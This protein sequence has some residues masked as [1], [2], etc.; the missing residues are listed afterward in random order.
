MG[1]KIPTRICPV[2][3]A[4]VLGYSAKCIKCGG[5]LEKKK[6]TKSAPVNEK[7]LKNMKISRCNGNKKSY[8]SRG[9]AIRTSRQI[10]KTRGWYLRAYK[11]D[12]CEKW[13]LT[14]SRV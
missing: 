3:D 4:E 12:E 1:Q 9:E 8:S 13:H 6:R 11:C 14:K 2:C 5:R 7:R 10:T